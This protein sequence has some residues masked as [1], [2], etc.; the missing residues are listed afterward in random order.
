L[1]R[2]PARTKIAAQ[3]LYLAQR[4]ST[5]TFPLASQFDWCLVAAWLLV[6]V[7]L[8]L[9][10]VFP[11]ALT[12][13]IL[14]PAALALIGGAAGFA[15]QEPRALESAASFWGMMHGCALL[16]GAVSVVLGFV[17]GVMYLL[18]SGRLKRKAPLS[19]RF[20]F[21]SL[22]WLESANLRLTLFSALTMLVVFLSGALLVGQRQNDPFSW[23][24]PLIVS[25]G[26]M[27]LWLIAAAMFSLAY[28]PARHGRKVAYLTVAS[29]LVVVTV[30]VI[31]LV[32]P[33]AHGKARVTSLRVS[34]S[35][36]AGV[37]EESP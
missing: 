34:S 3:T 1:D 13:L 17:V 31:L 27:S 37:Q 8:Y 19:S 29:F 9:T 36:L 10:L 35:P 15:E 7:Y 32:G 18:Q 5:Q 24:D 21:P 16:L 20:H 28:R 12:G 14:L 33:T 6:I 22:E 11:R 30:L 2:P 25:C 4:A 26:V 23:S